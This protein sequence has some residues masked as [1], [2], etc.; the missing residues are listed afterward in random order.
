MKTLLITGTL[1]ENTVKEYTQQSRRPTR[2]VVLNTAVAALLSPQTILNALQKIPLKG[3]DVI[4]VPGQ[5]L[6]DTKIIAEATNIPTF[7]GPRYAADL[8]VVLDCSGEVEL[9]TVVPACDLLREKLVAKALEELQRVEQ[10]RDALLK[11]PSSMLIRRCS[12]WQRFPHAGLSRN[13]G[14]TSACDCAYPAVSQAVCAVRR[15]Y[16]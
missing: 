1:A 15:R 5:I 7:K 14:C 4:L 6:G 13:R 8:P 9:S 10:N 12:G 2:V 3:V 11:K 16:S